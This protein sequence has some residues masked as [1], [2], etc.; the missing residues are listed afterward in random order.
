MGT[1][2]VEIHKEFLKAWDKVAAKEAAANPVFKEVYDSLEEVGRGDGAG[3][4][5]LLSGLRHRR[6]PLLGRE[7]VTD[8]SDRRA[9]SDNGAAP[10]VR[11]AEAGALVS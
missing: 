8:K 6:R 9:A 1:T 3:Q 10:R 2:P 5:L 7:E 11:A 4:A